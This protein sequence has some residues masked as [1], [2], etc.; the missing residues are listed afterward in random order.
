MDELLLKTSKFK[1]VRRM[2]EAGGDEP[3]TKEL[4]VHPGGAV[5]LP[6]TNDGRIVMVYN[7]RWSV[8]RELLELPAGTLE[9]LEEPEE[10][11]CR[12]LEEET[13]YAAG[14]LRPLCR[15]YTSPGVTNELMHGFV[16]TDLTQHEQHLSDDEKIKV[17]IMSFEQ[18]EHAM[19]TGRI[20]DG[21][22]LA[23]LL[24]HQMLERS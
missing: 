21:K 1:I 8:N 10:C 2:I 6:I 11:A 3:V 16:A 23:L 15:F 18:V 4:M 17:E 19:R 7:Y 14:T 22:T 9:P 5:I 12:E 20:M 13:G 24:Y